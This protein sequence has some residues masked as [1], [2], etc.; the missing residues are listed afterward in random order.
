ME[1]YDCWVGLTCQWGFSI[2]ELNVTSNANHNVAT[3]VIILPSYAHLARLQH[4]K[5]I[6]DDI[7]TS[8]LSLMFV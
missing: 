8:G 2:V 1:F 6:H 5:R 7:I 3:M 4:S